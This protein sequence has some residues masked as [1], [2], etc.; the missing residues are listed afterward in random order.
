MRRNWKRHRAR[1]FAGRMDFG[2]DCVAIVGTRHYRELN[3]IPWDM[4]CDHPG[5]VFNPAFSGLRLA[6]VRNRGLCS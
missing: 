6:C 2:G 5:L 1:A 3:P 4:I